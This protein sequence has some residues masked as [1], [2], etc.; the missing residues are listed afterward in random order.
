MLFVLLCPFLVQVLRLAL[1]LAPVPVVVVVIVVKLVGVLVGPVLGDLFE[2][3]RVHLVLH[4]AVDPLPGEQ[5]GDV[6]RLP[7]LVLAAHQDVIAGLWTAVAAY[8]AIRHH[9]ARTDEVELRGRSMTL[10]GQFAS[11]GETAA[12]LADCAFRIDTAGG[13]VEGETDSLGEFRV[14][15]PSAEEAAI[16]VRRQ[17]KAIRFVAPD[18]LPEVE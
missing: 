18:L 16:R 13:S 3:G 7:R 5:V 17:E 4:L 11:R 2:Q 1:L 12:P 10:T 14:T 9:E 15:L 6:G 8:V